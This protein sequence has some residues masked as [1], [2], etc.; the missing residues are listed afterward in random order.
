MWD[1]RCLFHKAK[2][3]YRGKRRHMHRVIVKG[4]RPF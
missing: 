3:D 2:N 1:N 4:D